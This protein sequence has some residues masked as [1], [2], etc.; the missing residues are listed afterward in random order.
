MTEDQPTGTQPSAERP[1]DRT[2]APEVPAAVA[3]LWRTWG[4]T[5]R[6]ADGTLTPAQVRVALDGATSIVN[7]MTGGDLYRVGLSSR[8]ATAGT[9][10]KGR[11]VIITTA[12]LADPRL[13]LGEALGVTTGMAIHEAGHARITG[14]MNRAVATA[15]G[16]PGTSRRADRAHRLSNIVEDERLERHTAERFPAYAGL[17]PLTMWWVANR[18]PSGKIDRVPE[19]Q[20][21]M[22]SLALAAIRYG[23][24]TRWSDDPAVQTERAWWTDWGQRASSAD[25]PK[26]HVAALTEAMARIDALPETKPQPEA[27]AQPEAPEGF[28]D[29]DSDDEGAYGDDEAPEPQASRPQPRDEDDESEDEGDE[30]GE[31]DGAG[32]GDEGDESDEPMDAQGFGG[33]NG[34]DE[35]DES[36]SGAS[37]DTDEASGPLD[38]ET[39]DDLTDDESE[40]D[41]DED[42]D[43]D[44]DDDED[45]E[46]WG[47]DE[48]EGGPVTYRQRDGEGGAGSDED[49]DSDP[50]VQNYGGT[51]GDGDEDHPDKDA[52]D[53]RD[54]LSDPLP[55]HGA[56]AAD[57]DDRNRDVAVGR[58]L[59]VQAQQVSRERID[60]THRSDNSTET[61]HV[62]PIVTDRVNITTNKA[63]QGALRAAFT[64]RRTAKDNRAVAR[65]GRVSGHRAFRVAAGFDNVFTRRDSISPDRLDVHLLVDA[66][67][68]MSGNAAWID[69]RAVTRVTM[70]AQMAANMAEALHALPYVRVHVWSHNTASDAVLHDV[71]DSRRGEPLGRIAGISTAGGNKDGTV[72]AALTN[73][74]TRERAQRE[75][76]VMVVISDGA[77]CEDYDK[78]RDA[79]VA[80]RAKG[81]GV[82]SVAISGGLTATQ[83]TCYGQPNVIPW[84]ND[85]DGLARNIARVMARV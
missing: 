8:V 14:P 71:W 53:E 85:W 3:D 43:E 38:A 2:H 10:L 19:T 77:P 28:G 82:I 68:S 30:D 59:D 40:D 44:W 20:G 16:K 42:E 75:T 78:V 79:A 66:S 35:D 32:E 23:V 11:S 83:E 52:S 24:H 69:G 65:S 81:V 47:D 60:V 4:Y 62:R 51:E 57:D 21:E 15:F 13:T 58:V 55:A 39:D 25:R 50:E 56:D 45:G 61:V 22:V 41:E 29:A 37:T 26:D 34:D 36:E 49:G 76:S 72:I 63:A 7:A 17:F 64:S 5:G 31:G 70:A 84:E 1:L 48:A 80:A 46:D 18:Y 27:P 54:A 74:I 67:G 6:D 9:D 33:G 12:A 73:I